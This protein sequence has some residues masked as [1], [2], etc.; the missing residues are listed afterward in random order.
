MPWAGTIV[1]ILIGSPGDVG[2]G[3]VQ[4][5]RYPNG[6]GPVISGSNINYPETVFPFT[7]KIDVNVPFDKDD[8]I[9]ITFVGS[10]VAIPVNFYVSLEVEFTL[11]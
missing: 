4:I 2:S 10:N 3:F 6:V 9:N 7:R 5:D 1:R 11:S 8:G